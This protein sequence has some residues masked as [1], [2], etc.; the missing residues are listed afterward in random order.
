MTIKV[1]AIS[2]VLLVIIVVACMQVFI[3]IVSQYHHNTVVADHEIITI[4]NNIFENDIRNRSSSNSRKLQS[5]RVC[6]TPRVSLYFVQYI[7]PSIV[8][9]TDSFCLPHSF[10]LF[11]YSSLILL[12]K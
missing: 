1:H 10:S 7:V 9:Y 11:W 5:P 6:T 2:I 3:N 8:T 12:G 4:G